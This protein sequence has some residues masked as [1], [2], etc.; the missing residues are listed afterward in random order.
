MKFPV[1]TA[2]L[3]LLLQAT[4]AQAIT[5]GDNWLDSYSADGQCYCYSTF[6]HDAGTIVVQTP[7]GPRTTREIC[8]AIGP[9]PGV[10]SNPI[11]NDLQCG[12]GPPNSAPDEAVCPGRVDMGE[13]GCSIIGPTWNLEKYFPGDGQEGSPDAGD[14]DA[15]SEYKNQVEGTPINV[16]HQPGDVLIPVLDAVSW[17]DRWVVVDGSNNAADSGYADADLPHLTGSNDPRYL[18]VL[19]DT[20]VAP[21]DA[22]DSTNSWQ[23][24]NGPA[25]HFNVEFASA[26]NYQ[27]FVRL[28]S[29][30]PYDDKISVG[31]DG[32]W[33]NESN[34]LHACGVKGAWSWS[35]C[36]DTEPVVLSVASSGVHSVH[37]AAMED[38][39]EFDQFLL[40]RL[41]VDTQNTSEPAT[42]PEP[43]SA[44]AV[45]VGDKGLGYGAGGM[46]LIVLML[47][48]VKLV[49]SAGRLTV[50]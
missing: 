43:E 29:S 22:Q 26:G 10:G 32:S 45:S 6:D 21:A 33:L 36:P 28:F 19:P 14:Q 27:V 7:A 11:Y 16:V 31:I 4:L 18:E 12:N 15:Q 48:G 47:A 35:D 8:D 49:R 24:A 39:L 25:I 34:T 17:D 20:R 2:S 38:G 41:L 40:R 23:P 13:A 30:G 9:G 42:E 37:F 46:G 5:P 50:V 44:K 3:T 1:Y